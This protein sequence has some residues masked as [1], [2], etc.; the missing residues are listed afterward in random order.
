M[1]TKVELEENSSEL[2]NQTLVKI[3]EKYLYIYLVRF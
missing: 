3:I 2:K 1:A